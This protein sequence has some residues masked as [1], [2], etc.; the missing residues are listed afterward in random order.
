MATDVLLLNRNQ[1]IESCTI[2]ELKEINTKRVDFMMLPIFANSEIQKNLILHMRHTFTWIKKA[3]IRFQFRVE[4]F[5]DEMEEPQ[6]LPPVDFEAS[7]ID[8]FYEILH[9][10][11][12]LKFVF[13]I[14]NQD[15]TYGQYSIMDIQSIEI[16]VKNSN[17][18]PF[19]YKRSFNESEMTTA[20]FLL[21]DQILRDLRMIYDPVSLDVDQRFHFLNDQWNI[22]RSINDDGLYAIKMYADSFALVTEATYK[23][24]KRMFPK[25]KN[26]FF[27]IIVHQTPEDERVTDSSLINEEDLLFNYMGRL[28]SPE[29]IIELVSYYEQ[30]RNTI[31]NIE[32]Q[33][34]PWKRTV[35]ITSDLIFDIDEDSYV[36][37]GKISIV[38]PDQRESYYNLLSEIY[39]EYQ[40][41]F[42]FLIKER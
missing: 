2:N 3:K 32:F 22:V 35:R 33:M 27:D 23:S 39:W 1:S 25:R 4:Y 19:Y 15:P 14:L 31:L 17:L 41:Q 13:G 20:R 11:S 12:I 37:K 29:D 30:I 36:T 16:S 34:V 9:T 8:E 21:A 40:R 38:I 24:V 28:Y 5:V 18:G 6:I 10:V 7:E 26:V 42:K